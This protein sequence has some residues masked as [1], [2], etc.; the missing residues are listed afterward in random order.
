MKAPSPLCLRALRSLAFPPPLRQQQRCYATVPE[1]PPT[2]PR[3]FKIPSPPPEPQW[4]PT[5]PSQPTSPTGTPPPPIALPTHP[6]TP[7]TDPTSRPPPPSAFRPPPSG[8]NSRK[9]S[10]NDPSLAPPPLTRPIGFP[11]PPLPIDN[12]GLDP[13][14]LRQRRDDFHDY[15]RHLA[16][17]AAITKQIAKPYFRDWSNMRFH[18]GKVFV[19]PTR[20]FRREVALWFPN[21]FGRTLVKKRGLERRVGL[22]DGYGGFGRGTTEVLRGRVS[23]VSLVGNAWAQR[24]VETFVGGGVNPELH[25]LLEEHRGLVQRVEI[26]W[27][28]NWLKW[29]ILKIFAV[30]N[31]R[32]SRTVEEQGRYFLVKRGVN[33][34]MKEALGVLNDKGGYVYLVDGECRIRWAGSAEAEEGERKRLVEGVKK[35]V[36]E[37]KMPRDS[38]SPELKREKLEAAVLEVVEGDSEKSRMVAGAGG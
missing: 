14:T 28:T 34:I 16:K 3:A 9:L 32:R 18:Q 12:I 17:R 13:R 27:E 6:T 21:F 29:W 33:D 2:P 37:A 15:D 30:P 36:R 19:A 23:V 11:T 25:A 1:Q 5:T 31:L 24:Q 8:P 20:L 26:N 38:E 10:T 35:L 4:S 22:R 7:P